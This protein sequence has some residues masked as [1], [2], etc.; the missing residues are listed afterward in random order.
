VLQKR[1]ITLTSHTVFPVFIKNVVMPLT[2]FLLLRLFG[3]DEAM[4]RE[5]VL[6]MALPTGTIALVVVMKL[7][8]MESEVASSVALSTITSLVTLGGF[9]FVTA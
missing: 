1:K 6:A 4:I 5:I 9:V 8:T 7:K 3:A 2:C